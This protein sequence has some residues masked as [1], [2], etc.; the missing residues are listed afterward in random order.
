VVII[1]AHRGASYIEPENTLR[2]FKRALE[3]NADA[4]EFDMTLSPSWRTGFHCRV[5]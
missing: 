3:M 5:L 2:S 1:I 4:I